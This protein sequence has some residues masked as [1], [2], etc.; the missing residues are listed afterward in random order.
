MKFLLILNPGSRS[1]RG[2]ALWPWLQERLACAGV[3]FRAAVTTAAGDAAKLA[4]EA[5]PDETPV[6]V[7]GDGTINGTLD[8]LLQAGR[9]VPV[10]GVFYTG[11]SPD[12]CRFN[13][14]PT[15]PEAALR[16]LLEGKAVPRDAVRITYRGYDGAALNGHFGCSCNIGLGAAVARRA[17]SYRRWLGDAWG[18]G[19]AVLLALAGKHAADLT[20]VLDGQAYPLRA[21]DNLTVAKNPLIASGLKLALDLRSDDGRLCALAVHGRTRLGLLRLVPGFY[22]G[23]VAADPSVFLRF[24]SKIEVRSGERCEVEFDGDPRGLLPAEI[25]VLPRAYRLIGGR[26]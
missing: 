9:P 20:L 17:N 24:C 7:G 26:P 18:T 16:A 2:R 6:A 21:V 25:E 23:Q 8:G 19:L 12:F 22:S 10:L 5:A 4:R 14:V 3:R 13:G 11:T 1:G 15:E